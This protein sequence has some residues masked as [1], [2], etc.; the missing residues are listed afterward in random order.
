MTKISEKEVKHYY[1]K[2]AYDKLKESDFKAQVKYN[3]Q[4]N[5]PP[6]S[7]STIYNI[8]FNTVYDH[9]IIDLQYRIVHR[10]IGTRSL[11][12][13]MGKS[14][15]PNCELCLMNPETIEHLFFECFTVK[16]FWFKLIEQY[17]NYVQLNLSITCSNVILKYDIA[18]DFDNQVIN[19]LIL[20]G[21]KFIY[22]CKMNTQNT[23]CNK[24]Q[25]C[26]IY[27]QRSI[28]NGKVAQK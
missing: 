7:W 17:G 8:P 12:Y 1:L 6:E 14:D 25:F 22:N 24:N 15:S 3:Q 11:L 19:I 27:V 4:F 20:Y 16:N 23:K 10:Y 18:G 2:K 26:Q 9:K 21:K 5:V 28:T 13:K